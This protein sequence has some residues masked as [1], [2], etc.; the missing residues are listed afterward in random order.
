MRLFQNKKPG[1]FL[2]ADFSTLEE[3]MPIIEPIA[4]LIAGVKIGFKLLL[5]PDHGFNTITILKKRFNLPILVDSK[6][7]DVGHIAT[8]LCRRLKSLGADGV[9]IWGYCGPSVIHECATVD[10]DLA[11]VVLTELTDPTA[12]PFHDKLAQFVEA[13]VA[14]GAHAVQA[15]GTRPD[16]IRIARTI[17]GPDFPIFSCGI[18]T[19]GGSAR[20]AVQAGADY[21]IIGRE[22]IDN[23]NPS[24]ITEELLQ[25]IIQK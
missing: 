21:V 10:E 4:H 14:F 2:A 3:C 20:E 5:D 1:I 8:A 23:P 25:Q 24:K 9:T 12:R 15:P 16:A 19:Q 7:H 18:G 6:I 17:S 13:A 22:I 11:L